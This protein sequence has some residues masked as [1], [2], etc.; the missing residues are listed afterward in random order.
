MARWGVFR[1]S[2]IQKEWG[3]NMVFW[4]IYAKNNVFVVDYKLN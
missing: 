4:V 2:G 1:G 3:E